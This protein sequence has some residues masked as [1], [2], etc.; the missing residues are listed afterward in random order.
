MTINCKGRLI[1]LKTPKVMGILN[2]TPDSFYDGGR[3][4][5]ENSLLKQVEKMLAEGATFIDLGAYSTRPGATWVSEE[6]EAGRLLPIVEIIL[7]E[8]PEALLS[9]DTFRHQI[10]QK[11]LSY[12]AALI[13]DISGGQFDTQ[14]FE[15]VAKHQAPYVA[16]HLRGSIE[17][18]HQAY[19]YEDIT[20]EIIFY[21]SQKIE[22]LRRLGL[23]NLIA[24]PG[25][26]FSKNRNQ[27][28]ELLRKLEAL[29]MLDIPILV[30]V[31]RK[32]MIWKTLQINPE[33]ALNG[34]TVLHTVALMKKAHILRVHD[35]KEA[36]ECIRL[37][38]HL[39]A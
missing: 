6:E 28:F 11:A 36:V 13:N 1:D 21:F 3:Y 33:E 38:Q 37:T 26:G 16:M 5:D 17:T 14:M 27:N 9:I 34:T 39:S 24:D 32:S 8:F 15:T 2:L 22:N 35:V 30:G 20:Q 18:M 19:E 4:K 29:Q 25:F 31:S 23:N 12:G 7:H 10:A